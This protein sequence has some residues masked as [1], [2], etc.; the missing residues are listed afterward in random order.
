VNFVRAINLP[1]IGIIENMSG[2]RCPRCG[3]EIQ[4][5][6]MGG[7]E[8]A[9]KELG[10]PFLGRVPVDPRIVESGDSGVPFVLDFEKTESAKAFREIVKE[11]E[12]SVSKNK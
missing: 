4:L 5:F 10:V 7:G 8:R 3:E 9:A 6:K 11:I 1:I 2:F 12:S